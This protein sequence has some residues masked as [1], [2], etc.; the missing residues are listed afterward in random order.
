MDDD[1]NTLATVDFDVNEQVMAFS[2]DGEFLAAVGSNMEINI[3]TV[4]DLALIATVPTESK[5]TG[6]D[7]SWGGEELAIAYENSTIVIHDGQTFAYLM[8][9]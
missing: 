9:V 5:P 2:K 4:K 7:F 6:L 3:W 1:Y 8:H